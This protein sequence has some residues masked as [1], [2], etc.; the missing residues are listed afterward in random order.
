MIYLLCATLFLIFLWIFNFEGI[1]SFIIKVA[2][3][4]VAL[5]IMGYFIGIG[6]NIAGAD[7]TK[8]C[9]KISDLICSDIIN[10]YSHNKSMSVIANQRAMILQDLYNN[11]KCPALP[12]AT[13]IINNLNYEK[14]EK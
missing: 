13:C 3:M 4:I 2:I 9:Q 6:I 1:I 7:D 11:M 8:N 5:G 10:S 14:K 12:L